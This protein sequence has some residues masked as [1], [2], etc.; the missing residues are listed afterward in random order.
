MALPALRRPRRLVPGYDVG[1]GP[2]GPTGTLA[3]PIIT[4]GPGGGGTPTGR[5]YDYPLKNP[6]ALTGG[7]APIT[8]NSTELPRTPIVTVRQPPPGTNPGAM[9]S[10][11]ALRPVA[12]AAGAGVT[13]WG[14]SR[15]GP[16][17]GPIYT[18][19]A[20][21]PR[22]ETTMVPGATINP[23]YENYLQD[24]TANRGI[25]Q[26]REGERTALEG[27]SVA[28]MQPGAWES[29]GLPADYWAGQQRSAIGDV[30]N[31]AAQAR[32]QLDN[33]LARGQ[34]D[35]ISYDAALERIDREERSGIAQAKR[36]IQNSR[37]EMGQKTALTNA[38][39][40]GQLM[41]Q[42]PSQRMEMAPPPLIPQEQTRQPSEPS[43][44]LTGGSGGKKPMTRQTLAQQIMNDTGA[45]NWHDLTNDQQD[46]YRGQYPELVP[47]GVV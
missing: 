16:P 23:F 5:V 11:G 43:F 27:Q 32:A 37:M 40:F 47:P 22:Y 9:F 25:E 30:R 13:D 39:L 41:G 42:V 45:G 38:G 3:P 24:I 33:R 4:R 8:S 12:A 35:R 7:L 31:G 36:G 26:Q 15:T 2:V 1:G 28:S 14:G 18:G 19:N 6:G 10:A 29:A 46:Y 21:A 20:V 34:I 17:G 44:H